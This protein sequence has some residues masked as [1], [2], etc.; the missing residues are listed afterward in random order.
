[1]DDECHEMS[2]WRF[3]A[4]FRFGK[5][6]NLAALEADAMLPERAVRALGAARTADR[7]A[8]LH[9]RLVQMRTRFG[10]SRSLCGRK[11]DEGCGHEPQPVG[12]YPVVRVSGDGESP[13]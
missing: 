4:E 2:G 3:A 12:D 1:F 5:L 10:I 6:M 7:A 13:G 11:L 8:Q 9:Q